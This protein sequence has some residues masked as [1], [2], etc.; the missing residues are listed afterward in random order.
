MR[1]K[2]IGVFVVFADQGII[3]EYVF[4]LAE[5]LGEILETLIIT[6]N[7]VPDSEDMERLHRI[8]DE[9]Y[10]R[11][12]VGFDCGAYKD[13]L[14]KYLGWERLENYEELLLVNDS[15]YGPVYPLY[16][17]YDEMDGKSLDFWGITEQTP[18]RGSH[19]DTNL[20]PYHIQSYFI[21]IRKGMLQNK[22]F[23]EFW[24][25]LHVSNDYNETVAFFE[26]KFTQYFND[27]GYTSGAYVDCAAFCRST[28]VSQAYVFFDSYKLVSEHRCPLIKKKVF[29]FPHPLVLSANSG[30]TA[31]R[32]LDYI[33]NCTEYD[34]SLIWQHLIRKCNPGDL[35]AAMH[36]D[37]CISSNQLLGE[38]TGKKKALLV[39]HI[40][41]KNLIEK[42]F[43]YIKK[44]PLYI[45]III[46]TKGDENIEIISQYISKLNRKNIKIVV[47]Q[48]R[49]RE[50]SSLLVACRNDI[51]KY[52][53][54]CFVHD[55]QS[56]SGTPYHTVGQSFMDILWENTISNT[57]YIEN[58]LEQLETN[59][60]LGVLGPPAP[61]VSKYFMVAAMSW[62][63]CFQKTKE[64]CERLHLS[65]TI[66]EDVRPFMLGTTF[67]CKTDALLPLFNYEWSYE[68][69]EPEP[70]RT[71][72]TISHA[73][74]RV[75]P[76]VAQ[77][78]GYYSGIMMTEEYASIYSCNYQYMLNGIIKNILLEQGIY[79]FRNVNKINS[80]LIVFC[81]QYEKLYI[82]GA[83]ECGHSCRSY[84]K[85][86]GVDVLGYIVS[87]GKR[88]INQ[89]QEEV[90]ELSE[91]ECSLDTGIVVA[92][93]K[94][95]ANAVKHTLEKKGISNYIFYE[96]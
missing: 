81:R 70:M 96:V 86:R 35:R 4:F 71:D 95:N 44:V 69:F 59:P 75:F 94:N 65:C 64:L 61:F 14:E 80:D 28:D 46:S 60:R 13:T 12:N 89:T 43:E 84:L 57:V 90:Y 55:K 91:I 11:D 42:C 58:V 34:S 3:D 33:A 62:S 76:Y 7:G 2:S 63:N 17:V 26:L 31:Q 5:K 39:A 87:D 23:R 1:K 50:I 56:N 29:L 82:Y 32:T 54:L 93:N 77:S 21:V 53:Y 9:I 74:E 15:C 6:I 79:E 18:I 72:G 19:Y 52:D 40:S 66:S 41:Y 83:G 37:Y 25:G 27:L 20:L 30:E 47:P 22:A 92:L 36:L 67:W 78:Q 16:E 45:D 68:D 85:D 51:L 24:K 8:S 49:G 88:A 38:A 10:V 73:V 48:N